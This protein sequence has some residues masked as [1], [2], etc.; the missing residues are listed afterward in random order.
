MSDFLFSIPGVM[1]MQTPESDSL[2][3]TLKLTPHTYGTTWK[4]IEVIGPIKV[5][6]A[7]PGTLAKA[8]LHFMHSL[9]DQTPEVVLSS[10]EGSVIIQSAANWILEVPD[11]MLGL[12]PG[13]WWW[14]LVTTSTTNVVRPFYQ[15]NLLIRF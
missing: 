1:A 3:T 12:R 15:G 4:G 2:P 11:Q 9:S 10:A 6:G 14:R 5:N 13:V 7:A 8:E